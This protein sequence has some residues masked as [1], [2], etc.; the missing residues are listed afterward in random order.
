MHSLS[1]IHISLLLN[2]EM[3]DF[4]HDGRT[5]NRPNNAQEIYLKELGLS[6]IHISCANIMSKAHMWYWWTRETPIRA[7]A[8]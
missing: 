7:C 8:A 6:L 1:L 4:I 5:V 3:C 2:V